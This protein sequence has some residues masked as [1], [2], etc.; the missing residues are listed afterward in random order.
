MQSF[1][2]IIADIL[3]LI[4]LFTSLEM[5]DDFGDKKCN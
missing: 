2:P 3:L 4:D 5:S 1:L